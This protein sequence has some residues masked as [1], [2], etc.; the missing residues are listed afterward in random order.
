MIT[1][2]TMSCRIKNC[3]YPLHK[4]NALRQHISKPMNH[5]QG[6]LSLSLSTHLYLIG[7][8][9]NPVTSAPYERPRNSYYPSNI[10]T[11]EIAAPAFRRTFQTLLRFASSTDVKN[12]NDGIS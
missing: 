9:D 5:N 6:Q 2:R 4:K 10:S 7:Q 11:R 1:Y 3:A 8:P 12:D